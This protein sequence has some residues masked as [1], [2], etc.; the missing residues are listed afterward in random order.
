MANTTQLTAQEV[1]C[2]TESTENSTSH[3]PFISIRGISDLQIDD[4]NVTNDAM[5][6]DSHQMNNDESNLIKTTF[7]TQS[8]GQTV[9]RRKNSGLKFGQYSK[10]IPNVQQRHEYCDPYSR[11]SEI[12]VNCL[13]SVQKSPEI[14]RKLVREFQKPVDKRKYPEYY[15]KIT[16]PIDLKTI[17][18]N[19]TAKRYMNRDEFLNDI[20]LMQM[21]CF[22][23]NG[24]SVLNDTARTLYRLCIAYLKKKNNKLILD[25]YERIYA[26]TLN[27]KYILFPS[28]LQLIF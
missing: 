19:I 2:Q 1:V 17:R 8:A 18:D 12:L 20:Y 3:P 15:E 7:E 22:R 11:I 28:N 5:E 4:N 21:N 23:F 14:D 27:R 24:V 26:K 25:I 10:R 13:I 6:T 16:N 9:Q